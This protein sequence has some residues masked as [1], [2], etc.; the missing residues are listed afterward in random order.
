[1]TSQLR[2]L[3][4]G[5]SLKKADVYYYSILKNTVAL[6]IYNELRGQVIALPTSFF[7]LALNTFVCSHKG[8]SPSHFLFVLLEYISC[9]ETS[10][11]KLSRGEICVANFI[12]PVNGASLGRFFLLKI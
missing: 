4:G 2:C 7:I 11:I 3:V 9:V 1:M 6:H 12:P 5:L 8:F 10:T